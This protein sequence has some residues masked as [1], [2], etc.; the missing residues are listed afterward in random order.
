MKFRLNNHNLL[1]LDILMVR[2]KIIQN[3]IFILFLI[4]LPNC[5]QA[6]NSKDLTIADKPVANGGWNPVYSPDGNKIAFIS[7]TLHTQDDIW[8]MDTDGSNKRRLTFSGGRNA[9]WSRD[10]KHVYYQ[11][12]HAGGDVYW[13]VSIE[14]DPV[15]EEFIML[16]ESARGMVLSPD[17]N[18]VA[19]TLKTGEFTD[20]WVMNRDGSGENG[21]T[22]N[23]GV[24]SYQWL[25][26]GK[27][28]IFE[29]GIVY[30]VGIWS[31]DVDSGEI[32]HVYNGYVGRPVYSEEADKIV[33]AEPAGSQKFKVKI[34][35]TDGSGLETFYTPHCGG[36]NVIWSAD[37]KMVLYTGKDDKGESGLWGFN[38][39]TKKEARITPAGYQVYSYSMSPDGK[40][41]IFSGASSSSYASEI[42]QIRN[43]DK[44]PAKGFFGKL[45][46]V[47][48]K[49][50]LPDNLIK[51][52]VSIWAP[53]ASPDGAYVAYISNSN[54]VGTV[55]I[56]DLANGEKI[57]FDK[58]FLDNNS[59]ILW[60][61][62][63]GHLAVYNRESIQFINFKGEISPVLYRDIFHIDPSMQE[64]KV[65]VNAVKDL[66]K[67]PMIFLLAMDGIKVSKEISLTRIPE[68][69]EM[70]SAAIEV[71]PK[72]SFKGDK[73][74]F[75]SQN[76]I[77]KMDPDGSNREMILN[78]NAEDKEGHALISNLSW[79]VSGDRIAYTVSRRIE[80]DL[81][82]EIW[83][84]NNDGSDAKSL[85]SHKVD[86]DFYIYASDYTYQ[87]FFNAVGDKIFYTAVSDN[88][89]NIHEI[90]IAGG[91]PVKL[92][93]TGGVFPA[94]FPDEDIL[95]YTSIAGNME[96]LYMM[97]ADGTGKKPF[98]K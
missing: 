46:S 42:W 50:P 32:G 44:E 58:L 65:L 89:P 98:T 51:S 97:N 20:L 18:R 36:L 59:R 53:S 93:T 15:E 21:L 14:N 91:T 34:V 96:T 24:R 56:V 35:N 77:W 4:F 2:T 68:E 84:I 95:I 73:I 57:S 70:A 13:R 90:D 52:S 38:I 7:S 54:L 62:E 47:F 33:F 30:G 9:S 23:F 61:A 19:Y 3:I 94:L 74:V 11:K 48:K 29:V 76:N 39:A 72:W 66:T 92:T 87:P 1:L 41:L 85:V 27:K 43:L 22:G 5:L 69:K 12:K 86:N 75:I 10:S 81:F 71:Q 79:S 82:M 60:L 16:P 83:I 64:N 25:P 28:I 49:P 63:P 40:S 8:V 78:I 80:D 45:F 37:G 55:E 17:E 88:L 26:D 6:E 31:V 67:T